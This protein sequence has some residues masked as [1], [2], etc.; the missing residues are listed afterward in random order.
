MNH[1][2]DPTGTIAEA[3]SLVRA[4]DTGAALQQLR[5]AITQHPKHH[6]LHLNLAMVLRHRDELSAAL[7]ALDQ[8]LAIEPYSFLALL[9]K[10]SLLEQMNSPRAAAEVYRNAIKIAP[11]PGQLHA[12]M[13]APLNRAKQ[14]VAEQ[15]EE[16]ASYLH[17]QLGALMREADDAGLV[18][19]EECVDIVAGKKRA[20][21]A[22]PVQIHYPRLPAIPFFDREYFKC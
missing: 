3:Q 9:S 10:G 16:L 5:E 19:F 21:N 7:N 18:R 17:N 2:K 20:Y 13:Q 22:E 1:Q 11:P 15:S 8:T 4:G 6:D 14:V 12:S